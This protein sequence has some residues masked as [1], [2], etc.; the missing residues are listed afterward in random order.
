MVKKIPVFLVLSKVG[1]LAITIAVFYLIS[2]PNPVCWKKEEVP[3]V[4]VDEAAKSLK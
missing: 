4:T 2:Y 3:T 1:L